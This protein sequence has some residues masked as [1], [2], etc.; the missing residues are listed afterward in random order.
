MVIRR[1]KYAEKFAEKRLQA[2]Q[3]VEN[4]VEPINIKS[5]K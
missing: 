5:F 1:E 2:A 4:Q 3:I